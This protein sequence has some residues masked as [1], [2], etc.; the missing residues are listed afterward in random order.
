MTTSEVKEMM[1]S[2]KRRLAKLDEEETY[3][4][5]SLEGMEQLIE[6]IDCREAEMQG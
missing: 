3:L 1:D 4:R 2:V 6:D 5:F